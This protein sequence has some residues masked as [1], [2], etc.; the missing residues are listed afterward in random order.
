MWEEKDLFEMMKVNSQIYG[1]EITHIEG[2]DD[3]FLTNYFKKRLLD[4]LDMDALIDSDFVDVK[5]ERFGGVDKIKWKKGFKLTTKHCINIGNFL[6]L[7]GVVALDR[8]EKTPFV[9][10]F[11]SKIIVFYIEDNSRPLHYLDYKI[12]IDE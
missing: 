8:R 12:E 1:E 10:Y 6:L 9:N 2:A 11:M 7:G 4:L 5:Y 3:E